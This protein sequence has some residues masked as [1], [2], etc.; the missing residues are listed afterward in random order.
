ML[1]ASQV[2]DLNKN[3]SL[4]GRAPEATA[5]SSPELRGNRTSDEVDIQSPM[6]IKDQ[7]SAVS[8]PGTRMDSDALSVLPGWIESRRSPA[9][10]H[11]RG[12]SEVTQSE[13][14][15]SQSLYWKHQDSLSPMFQRDYSKSQSLSWING[16][17]SVAP[18]MPHLLTVRA[19]SSLQSDFSLR[20]DWLEPQTTSSE[21]SQRPN[22]IEQGRVALEH[23]DSTDEE[24]EARI[25]SRGG[26]KSQRYPTPH[27]APAATILESEPSVDGT[28]SHEVTVSS[29]DAPVPGWPDTRSQHPS[30]IPDAQGSEAPGDRAYRLT[31]QV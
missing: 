6:C 10:L 8:N 27:A 11:S 15:Y 28:L 17:S 31:T 29:T 19:S 9:R 1:C 18:R 26:S 21:L 25:T 12:G 14:N 5:T 16:E 3:E 24:S 13:D 20:P 7:L 30:W 23:F 2:L 22:W 4:D